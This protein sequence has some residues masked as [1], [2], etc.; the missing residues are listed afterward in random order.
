M[1]AYLDT[2]LAGTFVRPVYNALPDCY[3]QGQ[4]AACQAYSRDQNPYPKNEAKFQWW[5]AGW[6]NETDELCG[7]T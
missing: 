2:I 4:A 7:Q 3:E 6:S 5:D 1:I